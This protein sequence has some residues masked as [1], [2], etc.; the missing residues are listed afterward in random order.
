[1][2]TT[3]L[4]GL[5]L[6]KAPVQGTADAR[7]PAGAEDTVTPADPARGALKAAVVGG[8]MRRTSLHHSGGV[9]GTEEFPGPRVLPDI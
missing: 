1:M 3:E 5:G 9:E 2:A 6:W 4:R 8:W 7:A